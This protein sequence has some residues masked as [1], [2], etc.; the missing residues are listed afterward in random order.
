MPESNRKQAMLPHGSERIDND[1][2]TAPGFAL[3]HERCW[4]VFLPGVPTEMKHLF[5]DSVLPTLSAH[6]SL[7]PGLLVTIKTLAWEIRHSGTHQPIVIPSRCSW[8]SRRADDVQ[9]KLLFPPDYPK[10]AMTALVAEF[11]EQLGDYV[12]AIDGLGEITG[13]LVFEI[14]KLMTAGKFTLAVM[15]TASHGLL[16]PNV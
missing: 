6:F 14:D 11:A 3:K 1:W 2:G 13:D 15:E 9:T 10:A 8:F 7:R 16:A 5:Q 4:F 12:F